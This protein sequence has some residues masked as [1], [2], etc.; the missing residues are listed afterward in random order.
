VIAGIVNA[1]LE[2][3]KL[4]SIEDKQPEL[5]RRLSALLEQIAGGKDVREQLSPRLAELFTPEV[6]EYV[7]TEVKPVWPA[8]KMT[9]VSRKES[10]GMT[11]SR[12]RIAKGNETRI[13][14]FGL[15]AD[16]KVGRVRVQPD[17]DVR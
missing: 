16:G 11:V 14:D 2:P 13:I 3:P 1:A 6:R 9:L 12:Y 15:G 10:A 8:G 7:A 4:V 17:P 5:A